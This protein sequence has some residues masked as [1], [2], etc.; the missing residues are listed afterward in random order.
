MGF[1]AF[2]REGVR[3]S[4]LLG[5]SDAVTELGNRQA[6]EDLGEHL[7]ATLRQTIALETATSTETAGAI[8]TA[9]GTRKRLGKS[10]EQIREAGQS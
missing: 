5:F 1:F 3:R 7:A 9:P 10:L 2:I 4:V 8:A 6:G